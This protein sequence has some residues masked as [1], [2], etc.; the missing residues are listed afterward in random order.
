MTLAL[1]DFQAAQAHGFTLSNISGPLSRAGDA[2][3]PTGKVKPTHY[4]V[5]CKRWLVMK[6]MVM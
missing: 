1:R 2:L 3:F 4:V 6:F 5:T